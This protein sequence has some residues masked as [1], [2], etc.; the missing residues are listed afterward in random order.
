MLS[1]EEYRELDEEAL[2]LRLDYDQSRTLLR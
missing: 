1:S 2:R